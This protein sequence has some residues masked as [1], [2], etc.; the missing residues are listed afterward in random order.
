MGFTP[1]NALGYVGISRIVSRMFDL[2]IA[3]DL[4]RQRK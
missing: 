3:K 2:L 1:I 4:E